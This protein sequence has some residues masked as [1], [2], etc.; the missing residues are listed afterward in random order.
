MKSLLLTLSLATILL[1]TQAC[2]KSPLHEEL[3]N[4]PEAIFEYVWDDLDKNY[5]GFL[6]GQTSWGLL[7]ATYRPQVTAQTTES[8]L[9]QILSEMLDELN[10]EHV[11]LYGK[12][13]LDYFVSGSGKADQAFEEFS[14]NLIAEKY[15]EVF[16]T[17]NNYILS[18]KMQDSNIAYLYIAAFLDEDPEIIRKSLNLLETYQVDALILDL[19]NSVGGYDGLAAEYASIFSDSE[20]HIYNSQYKDGSGHLDFTSPQAYYSTPRSND[21]FDKPIILLTDAATASEAE[22][23]TLHLRSF[24]QVLHIGD[25]TAGALSTVGPARFLS[26]G[27]RYEYSIER[28]TNPDGSSFE[29]SGIPPG[30]L[31]KNT[32]QS[33]LNQEDLVLEQAMNLIKEKYGIE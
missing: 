22:I 13:E 26:N 3:P 17:P 5:S 21:F 33:I 23:F 8:E 20:K 10:D 15:L 7:Y 31:T 29:K 18:G 1:M 32:E 27:W 16:F 14:L 30:Y 6:S 19:R 2:K 25:T 4:E 24:P 9:W 12:D 11:K 28:I